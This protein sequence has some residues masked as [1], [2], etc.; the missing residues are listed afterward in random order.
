MA[1]E[2]HLFVKVHGRVQGVLF[3]DFTR[4][5]ATALGIRGYVR[6]LPDG[7]VEV[8]AE[9]ETPVLEDLLRRL[10]A[11]PRG[12]RVDRIETSWSDHSVGYAGFEIRY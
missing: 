1:G 9:G 7:S 11:G 10:K 4:R 6:N 12:A 5:N 2:A 3:R 8:V